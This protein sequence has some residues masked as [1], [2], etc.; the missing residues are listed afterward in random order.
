M[1]MTC[2]SP[3]KRRTTACNVQRRRDRFEICPRHHP[4]RIEPA[5]LNPH[6]DIH[7]HRILILDFGSQYTQLI[8]RRVRE[9][10]VYGEIHPWT[11]TRKICASSSPRASFS[12]AVRRRSRRKT[13]RARRSSYSSW[14]CGA[15][16][17]LRHADH[18]RAVGRQ[19][20]VRRASRIRL[21]AGARAWPYAVAKGHRRP[22]QRRRLRSVGCVDEPRRPC[23]R[24]ASRFQ[25]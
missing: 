3:R 8:A 5:I 10:G 2:R 13:R 23:S 4:Y 1:C 9:I 18:G 24:S 12:R 6:A 15:R 25:N 20:R 11:W 22:H 19:G 16:H 7:A 14:A 21:C 17:L